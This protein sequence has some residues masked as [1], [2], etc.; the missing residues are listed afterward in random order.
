MEVDVAAPVGFNFIC[1]GCYW[2][3]E[4]VSFK[5]W[6]PSTLTSIFLY[7]MEDQETC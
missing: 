6:E 5:L 2:K 3:E 1:S 7:V 4:T